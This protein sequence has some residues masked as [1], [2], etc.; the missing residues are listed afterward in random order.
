[1]RILKLN[2]LNINSLKG[3]FNINFEESPLGDSGLF[4]ITGPTGAGK[5]SIL[6]AICVALYG[7]TPRLPNKKEL[8]QLMTHH[9]G[10]C[11]AEVTFSISGKKYRSWYARYRARNKPD[12]KFQSPK[13]E[14]VEED[15]G[16]IIADK[17]SQVPVKVE[18]LTG[19]DYE[20]FSRSIM[21]A[22]GNFTAF[23]HA[24]EDDRAVL[25]EKMTG[26]EIYTNISKTAFNKDTKAHKTGCH[27]RKFQPSARRCRSRKKRKTIRNRIPNYGNRKKARTAL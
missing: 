10:E 18:E 9:T 2:L 3:E 4:V 21:L 8:E 24:A 17:I 25:L 6:D 20:R 16:K 26:T 11:K 5:T 23:L 15:T 7:K 13:M 22:Q 27:P 19:L 14:L 12:G 1:M